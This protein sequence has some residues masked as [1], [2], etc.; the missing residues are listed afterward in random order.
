[1]GKIIFLQTDN[2]TMC[3]VDE[4][5]DELQKIVVKLNIEFIVVPKT[6][7]VMSRQDIEEM[8]GTIKKVIDND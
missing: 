1:M 6:I 7:S 4:L 5:K 3:E 2:L 8:L